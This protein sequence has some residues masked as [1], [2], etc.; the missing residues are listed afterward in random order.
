MPVVIPRSP[1]AIAPTWELCLSVCKPCPLMGASD[2]FSAAGRCCLYRGSWPPDGL[3]GKNGTPADLPW[4]RWLA[5]G[6]GIQVWGH[7]MH[8]LGTQWSQGASLFMI[9]HILEEGCS[10]F[11]CTPV[12]SGW[13]SETSE[14]GRSLQY[15]R[16]SPTTPTTFNKLLT[17]R[18]G[19]GSTD[20]RQPLGS[21]S[22]QLRLG[23]KQRAQRGCHWWVKSSQL[24]SDVQQGDTDILWGGCQGQSESTRNWMAEVLSC[25]KLP[26][27]PTGIWFP[28]TW[29]SDWQAWH[30]EE[31]GYLLACSIP[32]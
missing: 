13:N 8:E 23:T 28:L 3:S 14:E 31:S 29:H 24:D 18:L 27:H 10:Y 5:G 19:H 2:C 20:Y 17:V 30:P 7:M 6:D 26:P 32:L 15:H 22:R 16:H 21:Y 4:L 9:S 11:W 12:L 1:A 25:C